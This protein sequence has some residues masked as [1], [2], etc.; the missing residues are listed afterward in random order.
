MDNGRKDTADL[1][2][3]DDDRD[4][5]DVLGDL[6]EAAG[7]EVRRARDGDEG[8]RLLSERQPDL[9][10]LDVEMPRLTGPEMSFRMFLNDVGQD[11]IPIV[12]L[13]GVTNLFRVAEIV[14]TPY[15][16]QKP[17]DF[18]SVLQVVERALTERRAPVRGAW[19]REPRTDRATEG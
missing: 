8:L 3:V 1:L 16:M 19:P 15:F 9:V 4:L 14:G 12:L 13:S 7:H 18:D 6:L 11:K 10:L 17:Y 5:A 2:I